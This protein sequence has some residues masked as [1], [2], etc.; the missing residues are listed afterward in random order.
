MFSPKDIW[1]AALA[2]LGIIKQTNPQIPT[3]PNNLFDQDV[4]ATVANRR[5]IGRDR[6]I[7]PAGSEWLR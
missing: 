7:I 3:M 4:A 2:A 5:R 1:N 6:V